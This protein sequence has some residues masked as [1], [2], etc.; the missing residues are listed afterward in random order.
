MSKIVA[1]VLDLANSTP[2][3]GMSVLLEFL[4]QDGW[5]DLGNGVTDSAGQINDLLITAVPLGLGIYRVSFDTKS[6]M[7]SIG[8]SRLY[9]YVPVVFEV[10]GIQD[11]TYEISLMLSAA[12]YTSNIELKASSP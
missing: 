2:A 6:Y 3:A 9:P 10:N 1:H 8:K 12:G 11:D 4:G 7:Q 5:Q